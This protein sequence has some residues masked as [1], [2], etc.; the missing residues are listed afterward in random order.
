M[1][2]FFSNF[3]NKCY[4]SIE[5][6]KQKHVLSLYTSCHIIIKDIKSGQ[7]NFARLERTFSIRIFQLA[8]EHLIISAQMSCSY[9]NIQH[10]PMMLLIEKVNVDKTCNSK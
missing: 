9:N 6:Q 2:L 4:N 7:G 5:Y 10:L 1:F 3:S 8:E